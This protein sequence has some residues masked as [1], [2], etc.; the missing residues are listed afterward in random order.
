MWQNDVLMS[1]ASGCQRYVSKKSKDGKL[2]INVVKHFGEKELEI[3]NNISDIDTYLATQPK[4]Q[5]GQYKGFSVYIGKCVGKYGPDWIKW[6]TKN[7]ND[8]HAMIANNLHRIVNIPFEIC[9]I[10]PNDKSQFKFGPGCPEVSFVREK[11]Q[12]SV[13]SV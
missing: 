3:I 10:D 5:Y 1:V 12:D 4:Q 6:V 11:S 13:Y 2:R 8:E 7:N 9:L